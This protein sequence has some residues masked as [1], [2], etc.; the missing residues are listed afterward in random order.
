MIVNKFVKGSFM[1]KKKDSGICK[2]DE[3][4]GI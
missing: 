4:F 1:D 3:R 2:H